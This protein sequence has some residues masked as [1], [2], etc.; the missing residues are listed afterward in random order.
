M[1]F[2][3]KKKRKPDSG[4]LV[5]RQSELVV[6]LALQWLKKDRMIFDFRYVDLPG[7]DF[8][9]IFLDLTHEF[10]EV[11]TSKSHAAIHRR[12]YKDISVVIVQHSSVNLDWKKKSKLARK[13]KQDIIKIF[14]E[15]IRI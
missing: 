2:R 5:G 1:K 15:K 6:E 7:R 12:K 14:R 10:I 9:I 11:K 4:Q 8:L 3:K 13:A